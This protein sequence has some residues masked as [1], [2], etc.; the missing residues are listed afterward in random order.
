MV[1]VQLHNIRINASV[2][3]GFV[4]ILAYKVAKLMG[5]T[6]SMALGF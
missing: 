5:S 1:L 3:E 4:A 2:G 6:S